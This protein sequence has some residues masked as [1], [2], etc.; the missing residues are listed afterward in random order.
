MG[1]FF[2]AEVQV[3]GYV[4]AL[5]AIPVILVLLLWARLLTWVDKDAPAAHLP[6][7]TFNTAFLGGM[8]L[9][10]VLLLFLPGFVIAFP[11]FLVIMLIEAAVY[12][13]IR[14]KHVG[15]ADLKEQFND[16]LASFKKEGKKGGKALPNQVQVIS[17]SGSLVDPPDAEAVERPAYDALQNALIEP[18]RKGSEQID[19]TPGEAG[20]VVKYTVDGVAYRGAT[21]ERGVAPGAVAWLKT[22]GELDVNDRRKPQRSTLKLGMDGK[23]TEFRLDT[24][25]STAGEFVRLLAEPKSRHNFNIDNLGF[26]PDQ[27]TILKEVIQDRQGVVI[28]SAPKGMGLTSTLYGILRGH[29]A[30]LEHIHTI[31]RAPDVDLEGI[32]Q[33]KLAPNVSPAEEYKQASWVISQEP[34]VVMISRLDDSRTAS[35]LIRYSADNRRV[36]VGIQA[37]STFD[38]LTAWRK[39]VGDDRLAVQNLKLIINQRV[40]RRL[41]NACKVG[42]TPDPNTLRKL[43]MNPDRST[44]L[45][46]ARTQPLRD[47]KGN[48][49]P[50]EFCK[51]LRF[52]GRTG[53]YEFFVIDDEARDQIA[54]GAS[55]NQLRALF[56]KLRGRFLQEEALALVEKGETSVQEVLRVMKG[57]DAQAPQPEEPAAV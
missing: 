24:A 34:E 42:Y 17:K 29:D 18:L 23:R 50:C 5:K 45:Y 32:T 43:G 4:S 16:W 53:V 6:R 12:L 49:V 22:A 36:Y 14:S 44:T 13:V 39:T 11:A 9:A 38:A 20:A 51:D 31:E 33:N 21:I 19:V 40:L 1:L 54:G 35:D 37:P 8:I 3:G 15:L 7:T 10:F 47:Q 30:F 25:G 55:G 28:V 41:C 52:K 26:S 56:R 48:P 46:Q 57:G 2:L 27:K